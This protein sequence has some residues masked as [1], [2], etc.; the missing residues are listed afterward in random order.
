MS[1]TAGFV[2]IC[3]I[4]C[5]GTYRKPD[6]IANEPPPF[7][8][9][10]CRCTTYRLPT[11]PQVPVS[12]AGP[13]YPTYNLAPIRN[14]PQMLP[15]PAEQFNPLQGSQYP[16]ARG[17]RPSPSQ[18]PP[19]PPPSTSQYLQQPGQSIGL[20]ILPRLQQFEEPQRQP[21]PPTV[22]PLI[23]LQPWQP[24]QRRRPQPPP[25]PVVRPAN[26]EDRQPR[27]TLAQMFNRQCDYDTDLTWGQYYTTNY[28]EGMDEDEIR[29]RYWLAT[30]REPPP[31]RPAPEAQPLKHPERQA[32]RRKGGP[33]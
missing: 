27:I 11:P 23:E 14:P 31:G 5:G 13:T 18:S 29:E 17:Q 33:R 20:R 28:N 2:R 24:P 26:W 9:G 21:P 8:Y 6:Q 30:G 7:S 4:L 3:R 22:A 19:P 12:S 10:R 25:Q 15:W 32:R 1:L 16:S